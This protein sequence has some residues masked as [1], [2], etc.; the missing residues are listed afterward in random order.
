MI[1]D[2]QWAFWEEHGYL[3]VE[4][5]LAPARQEAVRAA[6]E[7]RL[8]LEGPA[9]GAEGSDNPGVRRLC[10]LYSKGEVFEALGTEPVALEM[11]RR[12][13]GP[14][15][16]WQAMNFHDPLPGDLRCHQSIHADRA[17]FPNCTGYVNVIWAID[18]MTAENGATL[19]V[20]GSHKKPWPL[21]LAD[22]KDPVP[23]EILVE[24]PAGSAVFVHGD[25]WHGGRANRST[26]PRRVIHMGLACPNTAPQYEIAGAL[27][28][29]ARAR[30]GA[31]RTLI[32]D[33]IDAFGY[34][35]DPTKGRSIDSI[36]DE[37]RTEA[38]E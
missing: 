23:G 14:D 12:T 5:V 32:P 34:D 6:L 24:C 35:D 28:P 17:F 36:L 11:A 13:I 33:R 3:V 25:T 10:N 2:T 26:G 1:S 20:P 38:V 19:L 15:I 9:A 4:G 29:E 30:L 21:D 37:R 7:A 18:A 22:A 31:N 27:A 8:A 16:R